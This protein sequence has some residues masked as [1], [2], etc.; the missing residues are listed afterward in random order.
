MKLEILGASTNYQLSGGLSITSAVPLDP[1]TVRLLTSSTQ[2]PG[3]SY[4]MTVNN[5]QDLAGNKIA[6]N[7]AKTF[8]A[9]NITSNS[10]G[11][12]IWRSIGGSA[13]TDLRND[14]N[15]PARPDEDYAISSFDTF[16]LPVLTNSDNNTYGGRMRAWITPEETGDY[17]FF[18][19]ADDQGELRVSL[20][21]KFDK[22]DDPDVIANELPTAVDTSAGDTFQETGTD[23]SVSQPV[24]LEKGKR[25]AMQAL[26]KESNGGD[27]LQIAWRK[28]GDTTAADQLTPIPSRFLSYYGPVV[29][30]ST[31]T[32]PTITRIA[33]DAGQIVIDWT[34][35]TLESSADLKGWATEQGAAQPYKTTPVGRKFFR[36][37]R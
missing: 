24:H 7:S 21:D 2:T 30:T 18:I 19:R 8:N 15:Y 11:V 37:K 28:V 22:F 33:L 4:T 25:Y 10:V 6:V 27:Y 16:L 29:S 13:V 5:L 3:G 35:S 17:E 20:D 12:E 34:G 36:A 32:D 9:F 23:D 26:W 31:G 14:T 1:Q